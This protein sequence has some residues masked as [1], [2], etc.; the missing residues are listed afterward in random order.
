MKSILLVAKEKA[1][2]ETIHDA[3]DPEFSIGDAPDIE[4]A[5]EV[6]RKKRFDVLFVDIEMLVDAK[7]ENGYKKAFRPFWQMY[8]T[9]EIVVLSSKEMIRE[10]VK[11]VKAGASDYLTYP[12]DPE[13]IKLIA[14][15]FYDSIVKASELDYLRDRFWD[16]AW[17]EMI[18]TKS[19]LM[20]AVF[21]KIRSVAPTRST[22]LLTGETG[23]G[24]GV[25]ANII[26]QHSNRREAQFI[27]LHCGAVPDTLLESELFGHEKGAFTG[28]VKR[29]LGK[30]EMAKG[31]TIFLDEIGT[32]TPTAQIKLLQVLQDGSFQR[33]GGEETLK[34]DV[35]VIAAT[36]VDLKSMCDDG[37][38]RKDLF[39][40]LNVFPIEVPPLRNRVEDIP[41]F[42][43]AFLKRMNRENQ[44]E[45][46]D[47]D[48]QAMDALKR[49]PWPG[50]IRELENLVERAYILENS[51]VLM[52]E[53]FPGELFQGDVPSASIVVDSSLKLAE[54]KR[55]GLEKIE[56]NYLKE[57]LT[58][59]Q[60]KI[61]D[62]AATAGIT[63]RQLHKL[64]AKHGLKKEA[65]KSHFTVSD[66]KET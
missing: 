3:L 22:V 10:A 35:R 43:A 11:A 57:L 59:H 38:F 29:K 2:F 32:I 17:L 64:M 47:I 14:D 48:S 7:Q 19:A 65:F 46:N 44:K 24:K 37:R 4:T 54:V 53:S 61:N 1:V 34:G 9:L 20:K 42:V 62:S 15:I 52:P 40:R 13:E 6:L 30:F 66:Q 8:P 31:G 26:H 49:Y 58:E 56:R 50:N 27:A 25:M 28:A 51:H 33:V 5:L 18:Q 55:K 41:Y 63:T 21:E 23:T 16:N 36:N 39:F 60:G 45:I 12:I